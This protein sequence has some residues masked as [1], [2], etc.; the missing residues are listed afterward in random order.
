V[1]N[2]Y[3]EDMRLGT[4]SYIVPDDILPNV[5]ALA[6][7]VDD[8]ELLIFEYNDELNS[9]PD[10]A[11]ISELNGIASDHGMTFTIHLPLDLRLADDRGNG[12]LRK[13]CSVVKRTADLEPYA[14]VVHLEGTAGTVT[15][16]R[17]RAV[18]NAVECLDVL[19]RETGDPELLCVENLDGPE[20]VTP[21]EVLDEAPVAC[22]IDVGHL[23]KQGRD[24]LPYLEKLLPRTRVV[25]LHGVGSRD[26]TALSVMAEDRIDPVLGLLTERFQGVLTFEVFSERDLMDCME[27]YR[28]SMERLGLPGRK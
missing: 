26:H 12:S 8:V 18:G 23:W 27:T 10:R 14:Y 2:G 16:D 15:R 1:L 19:A 11:V 22:C 9:M 28:R 25:H 3:G 5:R 17:N 13:A 24:P 20:P 7:R 21:E 6:G 4:T